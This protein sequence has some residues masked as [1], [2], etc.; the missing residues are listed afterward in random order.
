M[1]SNAS[2]FDTSSLGER[3]AAL[4]KA[5]QKAGADAADA[6]VVRSQSLNV[7][8][9]LGKVEETDRAESD[10]FSLRVFVGQKSAL[11]SANQT[12]NPDV[13]AERA[14]A[15]ARVSPENPFSGLA[16]QDRL[17]REFTDLDML[18]QTI[19]SVEELEAA[20]RECEDAAMAI[21]GITNSGGASASWGIGGMVLA[22]S[23]GFEGQYIASRFS[24]SISVIAGVGAGM[25][26]DYD[27]DSQVHLEDLQSAEKIG[28]SAAERTLKR[29]NPRQVKTTTAPVIFDPR[30]SNTLVG[31]FASAINGASIA[32]K[33]SFLREKM[34]APIFAAGVEITD[35]PHIRR[36]Q[37]SRPFDGEGVANSALTLI[38]D[39]KL[40]CW[41]LDSAT[42]SELDLETNGRASR[43]GS[44]TSPG[45]TNL[46]LMPGELSP[47]EM[48]KN[49]GTGLYVTEL[50]G[51][52][53]NLVSGDYS[54]GASGYWI[55][56]GEPAYPVSEI[57]I[58]GNLSEMFSRLVPA[59]DLV[60]RYRT[61]APTL[62]IEEMTIAG[63]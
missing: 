60:Y 23:H 4:V 59:N 44:G 5:A 15:M 43:S 34:G 48:M 47:Q 55:E 29:M 41:L 49:I 58:A 19:T 53:V 20:A 39:G 51:Q 7:D 24:R 8:V 54:R 21:N 28:I 52:G 57:T 38:D 17:A 61:N 22:T 45:S 46:A 27:Y 3:A 50:I 36:G 14:V 56:N 32:R 6:V 31:H 42:A 62:L 10:D 25:E 13:L 26:R 11:V 16:A 1:K 18:D 9:R 2:L 30:V 33:T 12:D 40:Q 63:T 37:A 35:D